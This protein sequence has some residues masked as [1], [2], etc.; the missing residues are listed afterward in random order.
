M[1][2]GIQGELGAYSHIAANNLFE[3]PEIK[4]CTTFE[5]TFKKAF[6]DENYT[7]NNK[8]QPIKTNGHNKTQKRRQQ[9]SNTVD[10]AKMSN[11]LQTLHNSTE[12]NEET[13][14]E[15]GD[16]N[17]PAAP[18]S[19]GVERTTDVKESPVSKYLRE[20]P[21]N[22]T[23]GHTN[24]AVEY[25]DQNLDVNGYLDNYEIAYPILKE[26]KVPA[27]IFLV[28]KNFV[29]Q[30]WAWWVELWNY[31]KKI[32]PDVRILGADHEG[33]HFTGYELPIKCIFNT[34]D[35]GYSTSELR[36]RVFEAEKSKS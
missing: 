26:Y 15:M 14:N 19:S 20:G 18:E 25:H 30:P 35:H 12:D 7:L 8:E 21:E 17:P 28:S 3:D 6:D 11:L 31:L 10:T 36:K 24:Q 16:F 23:S 9:P 13:E 32:Q 27:T 2:I 22:R 1:K 29:S 33:T 4:T 34:R 5:E